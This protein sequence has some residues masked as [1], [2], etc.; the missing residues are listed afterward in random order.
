MQNA[1][2]F[3]ANFPFDL[4]YPITKTL[5]EGTK[6]TNINPQVTKI[7]EQT[8]QTPVLKVDGKGIQN[9]R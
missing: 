8:K 1:F 3:W 9:K 7:T 6:N 5:S 2:H 4:Q